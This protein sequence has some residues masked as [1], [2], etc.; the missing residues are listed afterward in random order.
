MAVLSAEDTASDGGHQDRRASTKR[1][2]MRARKTPIPYPIAALIPPMSP[3]NSQSR[4]NRD[5]VSDRQKNS[6]AN[7]MP[8][9]SSRSSLHAHT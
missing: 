7:A 5:G 6:A 2:T 8:V 4:G 3:W 1:R 9:K